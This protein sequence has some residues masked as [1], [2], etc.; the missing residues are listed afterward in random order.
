MY[1][2]DD[3]SAICPFKTGDEEG[4]QFCTGDCA[5][6]MCP[7]DD[8]G[9]VCAFAMIAEGVNPGCEAGRSLSRHED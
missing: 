4:S 1:D 3:E 2:R 6:A 8:K 5:L 9:W 7:P